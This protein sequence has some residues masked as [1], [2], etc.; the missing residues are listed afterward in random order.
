MTG[1]RAAAA[2]A[3]LLGLTL[4]LGVAGLAAAARPAAAQP[5]PERVKTI[6]DVEVRDQDGRGWRFSRDLLSGR[7]AVISFIYTTCTASCP[8]V[9]QVFGEL[10]AALAAAGRDDVVLLSLTRDPE[11]D[12][13]E[14]LKRWGQ[15]FGARPGWLLLS[16]DKAAMDELLLALTGDPARRGPHSDA[17]LIVDLDQGIW[18][19]ESAAGPPGYY[20][21]IL[22]QIRPSATRPRHQ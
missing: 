12:T 5:A 17:V 16:G 15:R 2:A 10:Q 20:L 19:R 21:D 18:R 6:P 8:L 13:P 9:G 4:A 3:G 7:T 11:T 22:D 1:G 14:R